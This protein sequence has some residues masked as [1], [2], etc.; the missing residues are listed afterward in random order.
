MFRAVGFDL[1]G[2]YLTDCWSEGTREMLSERFGISVED[3]RSAPLKDLEKGLVDERHFLGR[4]TDSI[5]DAE[6]AILERNA[7]L[8]PEVRDLMLALRGKYT[9]ALM[10]NEAPEW[11]DY[12]LDTFGLRELFD[13]LLSSCI[14]GE[15]KP[16]RAYF[17]KALD[18]LSVRP[19][20]LLFI[21]DRER[22]VRAAHQE[23]IVAVLFENPSQ[24]RREL[25]NKVK[26]L[27]K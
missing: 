25:E 17:R 12:R 10:N 22:N 9:L 3:M 1:G 6:R 18:I 4:F 2:V 19:E 20:E 21:D 16:S 14:I 13:V 15:A 24:L 7:V 11:N 27:N 23:G 5:E 26:H 8:H